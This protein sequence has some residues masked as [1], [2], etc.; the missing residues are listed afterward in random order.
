MEDDNPCYSVQYLPFIT[1]TLRNK[2]DRFSNS[3]GDKQ[4]GFESIFTICLIKLT[5]D[6]AQ[7][8]NFPDIGLEECKLSGRPIDASV[9]GRRCWRGWGQGRCK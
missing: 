6:N 8:E 4:I 1:A 5:P 3:D 2:I 7:R 9:R